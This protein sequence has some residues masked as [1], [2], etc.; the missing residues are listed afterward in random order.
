MLWLLERCVTD[1]VAGRSRDRL[2]E[3]LNECEEELDQIGSLLEDAVAP[4]DTVFDCERSFMLAVCTTVFDCIEMER[5]SVL[6][7][8]SVRYSRQG[9][10]AGGTRPDTMRMSTHALIATRSDKY[11]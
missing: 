1:C 4:S 3:G 7:S 10:R 11:I 5:D 9:S 6:G 8:G 2:C